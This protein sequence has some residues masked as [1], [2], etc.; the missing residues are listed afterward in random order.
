MTRLVSEVRAGA[1]E[2]LWSSLY[3][4]AGDQL[5]QRLD[6]LLVV[7]GG[8]RV[9][10]LER[11]RAGPARLSAA[12]MSRSLD[13][14]LAVRE[15][16][17]GDLDVSTVPAGRLAAL[18]RY[19]M[20][21][22]A[23]TLRQMTVPRRTATLLA[24]VRHLET[25]AADEVL[26]LFDLLYAT[27]IEA[28]AERVSVKE[29]LAALPR[30]SRAATRLATGMRVLLASSVDG[31][32]DFAEVWAAIEAVVDRDHLT[33]AV[34]VIDELVADDEDSEGARRAE[35]IKRFATVRSFWPALVDVLP[36]D[37]AEA[38][39]AV[40]AAARVLPELF[41]RKKVAVAEIDEALLV[42]S[43]RR[44]ALHR[45]DIEEGL[46]DRRAYTLAVAE[47]LHRALRRRDVFVVGTGRWGD[48]RAKLLDED[49]WAAEQS[50]VLAALQLPVEPEG[51]L[52]G[53]ARK[54]D[55]AYRGVA[56]R[57]PANKPVT[58]ED[59]HVHVGK[60]VAQ[61]EPASLVELRGLVDAMMPRV[62]LPELILEVHAWT[63]CLSAY[64]HISEAN[65]RMDD[66]ALSVAAC[67]VAEACNLG[68]TP[69]IN[70]S[71]P[72]LTRRRLSNVDQNYVRAETHRAANAY[73]IEHQA[74][75]ELAQALG[76]G[77]VASVDGMRF[78]VPVATVNAGPNPRYFGRGRGI[79]WL[80][81]VNDQVL[82]IGAVVV[83]GTVRDSLFILDALLDIDG[84]P[85]PDQ[86][87][88]DTA[89]YSDQVFGLF[90]LLGFQFS[91]RLAG[92]PDQRWWR[93]DPSADYGPL[94]TV[95]RHRVN[96]DLIKDSWPDMLRLAGSL[97]AHK[98]RASEV[99][100]VTQGD[101]RPTSLGRALA[102]YGRIAK[103]LH[104]LTW[105]DD[106]DYRRAVGVRLNVGEGRHSLARKM[107]FGQ[108]GEI[109][110]RY[111]EGQEDQLSALGLVVNMVTLW[112]TKYQDAALRQLR[113]SGY[114][115]SDED[116]ARLSPLGY[117]HINFHGHYSFPLPPATLRP[118]RDP[119]AAD[120]D[121]G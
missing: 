27:K 7:P 64:T 42:G 100:R 65:A 14:L 46:I 55:D 3:G 110:Q 104:L 52:A 91:P 105:V 41:G 57:L 58:I 120:Q 19:G 28:K 73:L 47:T 112:N 33:A 76:G 12:E 70:R 2:R 11:L 117:E 22:H 16:G 99:M 62:D 53:L 4:I 25:Q 24:T 95:G 118:L 77:L 54:L 106:P 9:S 94:N 107:F 84:G 36:L 89:S 97:M 5:R 13:R 86:I 18:A 75:I 29:R 48:P 39:R 115:V 85:R 34:G 37:A 26:D 32:M 102:E 109:R 83:P 113:A 50:T 87:V 108:K 71:H 43:W 56:A 66:L 90:R 15:L 45:A 8:G 49:E 88:T 61:G 79:T 69:V 20:V 72:A 121:D 51:H 93:I 81:I 35:L 111:R 6:G 119:M 31:G 98:V 40:L 30:L 80:N 60:L 23:P 63:G 17:A 10:E 21:A 114:P 68:Y 116:I 1:A 82:G 103:T 67:L 96:L 74:S 101:G 92:L 78:V 44:L 38:G 59:G